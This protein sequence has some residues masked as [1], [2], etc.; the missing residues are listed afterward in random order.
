MAYVFTHIWGWLLLSAAISFAVTLTALLW[1]T[2]REPQPHPVDLTEEFVPVGPDSR[3]ARARR[4]P[5]PW[6]PPVT[7]A[8]GAPAVAVPL[9]TQ[10]RTQVDDVEIEPL[11]VDL[12]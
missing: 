3:R 5:R 6:S 10:P 7:S 4:A 11:P 12:H 1:R 8:P 9:P 2:A